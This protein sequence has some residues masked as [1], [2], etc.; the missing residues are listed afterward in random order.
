MSAKKQEILNQMINDLPFT[1]DFKSFMQKHGFKT[2]GDIAGFPVTALMKLEG[3]TY[4]SLQELVSF[5]EEKD[6]A[7]LLKE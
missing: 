6:M 5:L 3:F 4:H 7:N 2:I 1:E